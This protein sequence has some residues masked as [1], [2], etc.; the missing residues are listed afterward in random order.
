MEPDP[1]AERLDDLAR[2]ITSN[3]RCRW[4]LGSST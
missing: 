4:R 3:P 2:R 1:E